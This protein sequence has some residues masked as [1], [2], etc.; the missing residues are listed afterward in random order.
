M[1]DNERYAILFWHRTRTVHPLLRWLNRDFS[2]CDMIIRDRGQW[3]AIEPLYFTTMTQICDD[4][5]VEWLKKESTVYRC[6]D[7]PAP[8]FKPKIRIR[9]IS[10]VGILKNAVGIH[11][12]WIVTPWQLFNHVNLNMKWWT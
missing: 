12:P 7:L 10:C 5:F 11:S 8:P 2:H 4:N 6:V 9:T 3:I 1:N